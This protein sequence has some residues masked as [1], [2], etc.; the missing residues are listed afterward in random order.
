MVYTVYFLSVYNISKKI[1]YN[2]KKYRIASV[3]HQQSIQFHKH[4]ETNTKHLPV[5]RY[6]V[7]DFRNPLC[8]CKTQILQPQ[9]PLIKYIF[10]QPIFPKAY[11]VTINTFLVASQFSIIELQPNLQNIQVLFNFFA[12]IGNMGTNILTHT[13]SSQIKG[14]LNFDK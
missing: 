14:H 2:Q 13:Y 4:D 10:Q 5:A 6:I 8:A 3:K 7:R 9:T 11:S 12:F 1:Q